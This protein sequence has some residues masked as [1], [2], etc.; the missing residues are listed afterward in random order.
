[1]TD[2]LVI[3]AGAVL[4]GFGAWFFFGP[5]PSTVAEIDG[6]VQRATKHSS[7]PPRTAGTRRRSPVPR[8]RRPDHRSEERLNVALA[9]PH[10]C[11]TTRESLVARCGQDAR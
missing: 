8:A 3:A 7:P 9:A 6:G 1:M 2:V 11:R 10:G 5:K 4:T